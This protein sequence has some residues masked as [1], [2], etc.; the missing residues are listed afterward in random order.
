VV[1]RGA[2]LGRLF[3]PVDIASLVFFRIAFGLI[4]LWEVWFQ[5]SHGL[6]KR[7]YIDPTYHFSYYGFDW[8]QPWSG[9]G[10]YVHFLVLGVLAACIALGFC[11]R[12][13]TVLFFL[14]FTYV[15]LLDQAQYLNHFYLVV[16]I[17]FLMIFVP[18]HRSF[19]VDA[20][21]RPEIRSETVPAWAPWLIAAQMGIAYFYGGLAKLNGDWLRGEPMR[22]WLA[23]STGFPVIGG[24]FTHEWMVYLFSYGGLLFDL[25]IVA[26]LLWRRTRLIAFTLALGFHLTNSQLFNIGIF[27][28]FAIAATTLFFPPSWP[29]RFVGFSRGLWPSPRPAV[30]ERGHEERETREEDAPVAAPTRLQARQWVVVSLLAFFLVVQL[31]VPLRHFLYPGDSA[32]TREGDRFAWHMKLHRWEGRA[33]FYATDP[34]SGQ[35]WEIDPLKDLTTRQA[36]HTALYPD[37]ALQ[38]SHI[39]AESFRAEGYEQIEV[40]AN[41]MVSLDGRNYK[42]LIDPTVDLAAQPRTLAPASW[43]LPLEEP[44]PPPSQVSDKNREAPLE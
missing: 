5:F 11:Y 26:L 7:D 19:S 41:A 36:V 8:V 33:M 10:M 2:F 25:L 13:A 28:W 20:L 24:L 40:R 14:S 44:L 32:W 37:I 18:A 27:P 39:I 34:V 38:F 23:Q 21:F 35:T 1:A 29:R 9:N 17:S 22:S 30:F 6:I 31:L 43:I 16:L 12:V 15:F 4:M 3:A 42:P